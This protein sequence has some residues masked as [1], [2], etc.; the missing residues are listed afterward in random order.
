MGVRII[1]PKGLACDVRRPVFSGANSI[2]YESK[3]VDQPC[4][5]I[6]L[7]P[8]TRIVGCILTP[9]IGVCICSVKGLCEEGTSIFNSGTPSLSALAR[10]RFS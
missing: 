5:A 2:G 6:N 8:M 1:L 9:L 7:A 3:L 10:R 4:Y